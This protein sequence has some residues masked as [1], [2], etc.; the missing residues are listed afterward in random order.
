VVLG[1]K[2]TAAPTGAKAP[3]IYQVAVSK[4]SCCPE[5]PRKPKHTSNRKMPETPDRVGCSRFCHTTCW[6]S[7][8]H[9]MMQVEGFGPGLVKWLANKT[10]TSHTPAQHQQPKQK[11]QPKTTDEQQQHSTQTSNP[12]TLQVQVYP[13]FHQ[14]NQQQTIILPTNADIQPADV[15]PIGNTAHCLRQPR[16]LAARCA[17]APTQVRANVLRHMQGS[18]AGVVTPAHGSVRHAFAHCPPGC[19]AVTLP[20]MHPSLTASQVVKAGAKG[21]LVIQWLGLQGQVAQLRG[22]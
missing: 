5:G 19:Q 11:Q 3:R 21:I 18:A 9:A 14:H 17:A 6:S 22:V 1:P 13:A 2:L 8:Y 16:W 10:W 4:Q 12:C 20:P 15:D 7:T